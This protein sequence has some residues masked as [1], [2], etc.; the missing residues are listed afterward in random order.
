MNPIAPPE[1]FPE[2]QLHLDVEACRTTVGASTV[3]NI[4]V[5]YSEYSFSIPYLKYASKL[6]WY[7]F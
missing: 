4:L 5:P 2:K 6:H 1:E 7:L 3:T